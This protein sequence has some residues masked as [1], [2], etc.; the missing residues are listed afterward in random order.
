M[1]STTATNFS[2]QGSF[3]DV[4]GY[5]GDDF[6]SMNDTILLPEADDGDPVKARY[7]AVYNNV[8]DF[9]LRIT[10]LQ[11]FGTGISIFT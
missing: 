5:R 1:S 11:V 10:E 9:G 8:S 7:I 2:S 6:S 3:W 4:Q